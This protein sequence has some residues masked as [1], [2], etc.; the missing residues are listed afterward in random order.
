MK[1]VTWVRWYKVYADGMLPKSDKDYSYMFFDFLENYPKDAANDV[2]EETIGEGINHYEEGEHY[3]R[4]C[5]EYIDK[6]PQWYVDK[7]I[8]E[9][10]ERIKNLTKKLKYFKRLNEDKSDVAT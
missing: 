2:I 9:Y 8:K 1:K 3:R 6:P 4:F 5:W 7:K 10:K